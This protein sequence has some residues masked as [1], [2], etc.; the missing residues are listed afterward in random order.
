MVCSG[1]STFRPI[2]RMQDQSRLKYESLVSSTVC[3]LEQ[4]ACQAGRG[5]ILKLNKNRCVES[6]KAKLIKFWTIMCPC[7]PGRNLWVQV[8]FLLAARIGYGFKKERKINSVITSAFL[9]SHISV[10]TLPLYIMICRRS[11]WKRR[12]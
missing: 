8:V 4:A 1:P 7:G 3:S 9:Q 12:R 2:F 11:E 5:A 10:H 6:T